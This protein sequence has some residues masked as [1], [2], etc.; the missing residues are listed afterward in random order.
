MLQS[1]RRQPAP[2]LQT[3]ENSPATDPT[4]DDSADSMLAGVRE[5]LDLV[6]DDLR[7]T[8][9][10]IGDAMGDVHDATEQTSAAL[11]GICAQTQALTDVA[12][13]LSGTSTNLSAATEQLGAASADIET[14]VEEAKSLAATA[15]QAAGETRRSVA[16]LDISAKE[17]GDVVNL[18]ADIAR[19]TNL[20]ALNATIEAA[21]AGEAGR[22]FSVVASEVKNLSVETQRATEEIRRKIA[23]LQS[24]ARTSVDAVENIGTVIDTIQPVFEAVSASVDQQ[25]S[26]TS[27]LG[28]LAARAQDAV[29]AVAQSA[30]EIDTT[31]THAVSLAQRIEENGEKA[32]GRARDLERRLTLFLRQTPAGDRRQHRRRPVSLPAQIHHG[33]RPLTAATFD[34]SEGGMLIALPGDHGIPTGARIDADIQTIG[35]IA[36]QVRNVS[37]IG[38]HCA[39]AAVS[40]ETRAAIDAAIARLDEDHRGFVERALKVSGEIGRALET[41]V[42]EGLLSMEQLFDTNYT[43]IEGTNPQQFRQAAL[44]GLEQILPPLQEAARAEDRRMT[45]CASVDRNGYLPV[46]NKDYS[47]EPR[48]DDV[49]WN[50]AHC[51]NKRIFDDRAGLAAARNMR[52][53]LIQSYKR[54]MGGGRMILMMEVDAPIRIAGRH[55]GAVRTAYAFDAGAA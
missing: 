17:I 28:S 53:F 43:P 4:V 33:G 32:V 26:A 37:D 9:S 31:A 22:G 51:R 34:I 49:A 7:T 10:A 23:Q 20:L 8:S 1:M 25:R 39:F 48:P 30:A 45:F 38:I 41:A 36:L 5:T 12:S 21:R 47:H 35:K 44:A 40:D 11:H 3:A 27:V 29:S 50:T 54:D 6:E 15:T 14:R 18:I 19:Q 13:E 2:S 46:H 24:V 42:G 52:P 55:W 16:E